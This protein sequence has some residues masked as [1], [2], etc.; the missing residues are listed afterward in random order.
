LL[1]IQS[2]DPAWYRLLVNNVVRYSDDGP[3]VVPA[4]RQSPDRRTQEGTGGGV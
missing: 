4:A 1:D 2:T 3:S